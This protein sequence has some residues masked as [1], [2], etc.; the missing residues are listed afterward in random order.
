MIICTSINYMVFPFYNNNTN[1]N[2]KLVGKKLVKIKGI[3]KKIH[4]SFKIMSNRLTPLVI[5]VIKNNNN[6]KTLIIII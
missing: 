2:N 4:N 6:I 1:P 3:E 5:Q